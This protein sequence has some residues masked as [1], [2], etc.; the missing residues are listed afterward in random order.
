MQRAELSVAFHRD[1]ISQRFQQEREMK[2]AWICILLQQLHF[3]VPGVGVRRGILVPKAP[4]VPDSAREN[5]HIGR[6]A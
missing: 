4:R 1:V 5:R 2:K 3:A 6:L